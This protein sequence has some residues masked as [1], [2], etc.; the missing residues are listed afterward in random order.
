L[1]ALGYALEDISQVPA[2]FLE[3]FPLLQPEATQEPTSSPPTA[4]LPQTATATPTP[5]P[6][7]ID[8]SLAAL[9]DLEL[10]QALGCPRAESVTTPGAWE[11]FEHGLMLWRADSNLIYGVGPNEAWF[12]TGDRWVEGEDPYDASIIPPDGYYQPN[13]GFGKVWRERPGVRDALGW[14]LTEETGLVA[15]I[16]EFTNGQVWHNPEQNRF[17]IL[18][19]TGKYQIIQSGETIDRS[20]IP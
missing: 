17:M 2:E 8:G 6:Q 16:Q 9:S 4:D 1:W 15:I 13:R 14:A 11:P 7:H 12:I 20:P 5:C 18:Y 3:R 10:D 19:N